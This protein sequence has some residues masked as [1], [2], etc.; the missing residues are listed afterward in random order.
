MLLCLTKSDC[1]FEEVD[2]IDD[3]SIGNCMEE[4]VI[5]WEFR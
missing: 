3:V 4:Q 5:T 1:T 2:G